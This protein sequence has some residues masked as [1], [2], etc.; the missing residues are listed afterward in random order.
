MNANAA[1]EVPSFYSPFLLKMQMLNILLNFYYI[2]LGCK[3]NWTCAREAKDFWVQFVCYLCFSVFDVKFYWI[4]F[5]INGW[6]QHHSFD[7]LFWQSNCNQNRSIRSE[8]IFE[9]FIMDVEKTF[10]RLKN[11]IK[12]KWNAE[13]DLYSLKWIKKRQYE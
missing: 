7:I 4:T 2:E 11:E 3:I 1:T 10:K 6:V 8:F 9:M 12:W 13:R 5:T